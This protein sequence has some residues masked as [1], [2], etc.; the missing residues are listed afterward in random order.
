MSSPEYAIAPVEQWSRRETGGIRLYSPTTGHRL[1]HHADGQLGH[2][3]AYLNV[4]PYTSGY[5]FWERRGRPETTSRLGELVVGLYLTDPNDPEGLGHPDDLAYML[6][7]SDAVGVAVGRGVNAR[8]NTNPRIAKV[9]GIIVADPIFEKRLDDALEAYDS[10]SFDVAASE[11]VTAAM[12]RALFD[13]AEQLDDPTDPTMSFMAHDMS[14]CTNL[15]WGMAGLAGSH[16]APNPTRYKNILL[17]VAAEH[18]D[19]ARK[20]SLLGDVA[21]EP[22]YATEA[23]QRDGINLL[24]NEGL[25]TGFIPQTP[26]VN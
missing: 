13:S 18:A 20:I 7:M 15:Q 6:G 25:S 2:P 10:F 19:L 8:L 26:F 14:Y 24:Y 17:I 5:A 3:P 12:E 11:P 9:P 1:D 4:E 23:L 16:L 21:V 22:I